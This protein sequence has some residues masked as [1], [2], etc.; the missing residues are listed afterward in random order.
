[1]ESPLSHNK[2]MVTRQQATMV[3]LHAREEEGLLQLGIAAA[4][5]AKRQIIGPTIALRR[6]RRRKTR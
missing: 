4:T 3:I 2:L 5:S 6:P 1:M